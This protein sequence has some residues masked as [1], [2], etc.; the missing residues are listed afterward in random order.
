VIVTVHGPEQVI[1]IVTVVPVL[2]PLPPIVAA[3]VTVSTSE[4]QVLTLASLSVLPLYAA[5]Q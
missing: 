1:V 5:F 3:G 2:V 4:P